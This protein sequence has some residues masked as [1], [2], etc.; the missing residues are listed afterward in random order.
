MGTSGYC[1]VSLNPESKNVSDQMCEENCHNNPDHKLCDDNCVCSLAPDV[2]HGGGPVPSCFL[3]HQDVSCIK[4]NPTVC[5]LQTQLGTD[6]RWLCP[7]GSAATCWAH[8]TNQRA[9]IKPICPAESFF[10]GVISSVTQDKDKVIVIINYLDSCAQCD[11]GS[12]ISHQ[13]S[14]AWDDLLH[15]KVV[16]M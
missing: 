9:G 13:C 3:P 1:R 8:W 12:K 6:R 7:Q 5:P 16:P 15:F 4:N 11:H 14:K 10:S 2:A